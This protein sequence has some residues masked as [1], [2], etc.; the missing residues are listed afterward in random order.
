MF[1]I[2]MC[3]CFENYVNGEIFSYKKCKLQI[4]SL[5]NNVSFTIPE[6]PLLGFRVYNFCLH[7]YGA[8][9]ELWVGR[10]WLSAT[11]KRW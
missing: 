3:H 8:L 9:N 6:I 4:S 10:T 2:K 5:E 1:I 7:S 11:L